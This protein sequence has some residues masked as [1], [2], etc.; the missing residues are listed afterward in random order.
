[1][2]S[3]WSTRTGHG[4][5]RLAHQEDISAHAAL[6]L[7]QF[8]QTPQVDHGPHLAVNVDD[9]Q[10][11]RR[12]SGYRRAIDERQQLHQIGEVEGIVLRPKGEHK[13]AQV[14]RRTTGFRMSG[15]QLRGMLPIDRVEV[16]LA[17]AQDLVQGQLAGL[18]AALSRRPS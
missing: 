1:M 14:R 4:A 6:P 16:C 8:E 7:R 5:A 10:E 2:P 9:P 12:P 15:G 11:G 17:G 13:H 18:P 3:T